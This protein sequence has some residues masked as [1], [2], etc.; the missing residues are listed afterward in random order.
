MEISTVFIIL[1]AGSILICTILPFFLLLFIVSYLIG[2]TP[3]LC[4]EI[5]S[6]LGGQ[7]TDR[8]GL[9]EPINP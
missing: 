5:K 7:Y 3:I 9:P 6:C 4:Q 8:V 1:A 2:T